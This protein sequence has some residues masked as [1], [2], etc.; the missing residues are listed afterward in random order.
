MPRYLVQGSY[1]H[2][3]LSGL[4]SSPEDRFGVIKALAEGVGG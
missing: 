2:Q 3:G 1:T 4:V